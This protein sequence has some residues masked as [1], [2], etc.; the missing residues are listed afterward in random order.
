LYFSFKM[1]VLLCEFQLIKLKR[2]KVLYSL[3]NM[4]YLLFLLRAVFS[5]YAFLLFI[6]IL[7]LV[8]PAVVIASVFGKIRGGNFIYRICRLWSDIFLPLCG[9]IHHNTYE[10]PHDSSRQYVFVFNHISYLDIPVIMKAIR[11]QHFRILG[12]AEMSKVPVFGFLYR[13]AVVLVA[14]AS[15]EKR[16]KSV[17]QLK[18]VIN[19]GISVVI[20]PEG[21]FNTTHQPLKEFFDGAFRVAIETQTPIKPILFL[22]NYERLGYKNIFSLTPGR[23]R[24][25]YLEEVSVEGMTI[26]DIKA[27]KEKVYRLMENKL[28][29]YRA[30]WISYAPVS[31]AERIPE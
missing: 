15:A 7:L 4:K 6:A 10:V 31:N 21:T 25:V 24:S 5:I 20:A 30:G 22:D 14:R 26:K 9:I 29:Q 28:I 8:F 1:P 23:T 18:S 13:N 27:L 16:A 2:P 11:S 17:R 19:K 3:I 12:K